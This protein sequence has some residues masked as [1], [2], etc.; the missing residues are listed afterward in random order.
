MSTTQHHDDLY[1]LELLDELAADASHSQRSLARRLGIAL[2]LT[3]LLLR[4]FVQKGWVRA[5]QVRPNRVGYLLTPAALRE[6]AT[7]S[8]QALHEKVR[9]Y[10]EVKA[11][12]RASLA[13]VATRVP[14]RPARV[15]FVGG[16]EAAEIAY[17]CLAEFPLELVGVVGVR[18]EERVFLGRPV[19]RWEDLSPEGLAVVP[20]DVA[21]VTT[22]TDLES[23][24]LR[25]RR[26]GIP[27]GKVA[28]L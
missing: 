19:A 4:R 6:K 20:F 11:R 2:G 3:N 10:G 1:A 28:W 16:G 12:V 14:T 5:I 25:V 15:V 13:E 22:F 21:V 8:A 7:R 17:L 9:F 18:P 24:R 23:V 26:A 27:T